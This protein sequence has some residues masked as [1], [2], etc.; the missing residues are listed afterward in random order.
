[1]W[2]S[3]FFLSHF[4]CHSWSVPM[5]KMTG[6][7]HIFKWEN[8]HNTLSSSGDWKDLPWVHKK[9]Y[10]YTI[11]SILTGC[12]PAWYGNCSASD[13][14]AL[15]RVCVWPSTSLGSSFLPSRTCIPGG[16]RGRPKKLSKTPVTQVIE[17]S[18][19]YRMASDTGGP[20]LGPK[21]FLTASTLKP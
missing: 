7:S 12:I 5:L 17:C 3:G 18:L 9:F 16:V 21:G 13:C 4:V 10:S 2:F 11:E 19:C 1:M 6:L 14:K 20:S 15:Q 8:L